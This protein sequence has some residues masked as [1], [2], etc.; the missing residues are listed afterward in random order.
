MCF[1]KA[2]EIKE[3]VKDEDELL[4]KVRA[5]CSDSNSR[6]LLVLDGCQHQLDSGPTLRAICS[7]LLRRV[8]ALCLLLTTVCQVDFGLLLMQLKSKYK[9]FLLFLPSRHIRF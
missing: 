7:Q 4:D 2:F 1:C 3:S 8:P 9:A 6:Y 5:L